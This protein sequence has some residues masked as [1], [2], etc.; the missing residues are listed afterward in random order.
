MQGE[1]FLLYLTL[2]EILGYKPSSGSPTKWDSIPP[3]LK[4]L[5]D[6]KDQKPE[7]DYST[8]PPG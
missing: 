2:L 5:R 8:W 4:M 7:K 3:I 6:K 1:F